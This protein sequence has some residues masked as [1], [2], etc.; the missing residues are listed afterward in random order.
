LPHPIILIVDDN[1]ENLTVLGE[2]LRPRYRVRA[3][4]A[5]TRALQLAA[6]PPLP[7]L[8]LLDVM[9][10]G[11]S[12]YEVLQRLRAEP[13]TCD[14]PVIFTTSMNA[15]EDEQRGLALGA[16]DYITKPLRPAI[17]LAR[18][19]THLSLKRA[20][21][22]LQRDNASL[23]REIERRMRENLLIQDVTIRA[24]ARLAETRDNE[25]GNHVLRTQAFVE[26]LA[27]RAARH[28]RFAS[29]LD[30]KTVALI[31]KSAPL[32]DIGKVGIPDHILL[33]PGR[34][35]DEERAVMQTH[36]RMGAE[37]IDRAV[38][39]TRQPV[40][41]LAC[42]REI[43]LRHH[44]RWD[45]SGYPDGLAGE[46]IPLSARLMA[47]ADVFDAMISPRIYKPA[48][49]VEKVRE[50]MA[51]ERGRHFEP[52]LLDVFMDGFDA[53][54]DI[55]RRLCDAGNAGEAK[56]AGAAS[57]AGDAGDASDAGGGTGARADASDILEAD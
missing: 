52:E 49:P 34:L 47:V 56:G 27:R 44:E 21:D 53:F 37:A 24:L 5:G 19:H 25:T 31:A 51:A 8:I 11:M 36:A 32:H 12:G 23:E 18:V 2:L 30:E 26:E 3:A 40:P 35:T 57:D 9:M 39:D 46:A 10:P 6:Q 15:T 16:V 20:R 28:P 17:V 43:A 54:C 4:N 55:A 41:F 22:R 42:A 14:I 48:T 33:K 13:L 45:G 7:E 50:A 1:P 29:R 38:A